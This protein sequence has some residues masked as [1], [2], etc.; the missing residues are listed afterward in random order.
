M[1]HSHKGFS[2][3]DLIIGFTWGTAAKLID[4]SLV[5]LDVSL[6]RSSTNI[7]SYK[8]EDIITRDVCI[9]GGS[10]TGTYSAVLLGVFNKSVAHR[11]RQK[12]SRRCPSNGWI[13]G[14]ANRYWVRVGQ[15]DSFGG[16]S[17]RILH[18]AFKVSGVERGFI[19]D[20]VPE[21]LLMPFGDF[22]KKYS[23]E[24]AVYT[25]FQ[26][27][28]SMGDIYHTLTLYVMKVIGLD[29]LKNLE[30]GFLTTARHD[31]SEPYQKA[32]ATLSKDPLLNS[33]VIGMD[34][35]WYSGRTE[36]HPSQEV[37]HNHSTEARQPLRL[38]P[39]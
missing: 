13:S 5:G 29:L 30:S 6:P 27:S 21:D 11:L 34:R 26:L 32:Q 23:L 4:S 3:Q 28:Q 25:I 7:A 24:A 35:C 15:Y 19:P 14:P 9:I 1:T 36:A 10:S 20:P 33:T 17:R 12:S 2:D 8:A 16:C 18:A 31:N 39:L 38:R 37:A 22:V